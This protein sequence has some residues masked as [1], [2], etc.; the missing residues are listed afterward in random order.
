MEKD[1][2]VKQASMQHVMML[3]QK[4]PHLLPTSTIHG[5]QRF[6]PINITLLRVPN[7]A[8]IGP[9]DLVISRW[10]CQGLS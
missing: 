1:A 8:K 9:I 6:L 3:Q 10:L 7:L 2:Q 5:Y 4:Y